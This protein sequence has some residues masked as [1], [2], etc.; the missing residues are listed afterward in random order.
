NI[1][2][3]VTT[4]SDQAGEVLFYTDGQT[5]WD[6]NGNPMQNGE[7]IG[8]DNQ[9]SQSVLAVP[10]PQEETLFYF[11]T[12]QTAASGNLEVNFSLV[13]IKGAKTRGVGNVVNNDKFHLSP[14]TQHSAALGAG[15]TTWVA[16][17][18]LGNNTFRLYPVR[19]EG[20]GQPVFSTVGGSHNYGTSTG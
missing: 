17:H 14:N 6:L 18:K 8:G 3:G 10:L 11:F 7:N 16:F 5:V 13:D 1:P 9:A 2:A 15:D 12:T 20:I 19:N 4:I